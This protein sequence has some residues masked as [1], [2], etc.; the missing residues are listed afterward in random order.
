MYF[1]QMEIIIY[2]A[3]NYEHPF[4]DITDEIIDSH[5]IIN[6]LKLKQIM[7]RNIDKCYI[8]LSC[9]N[10]SNIEIRRIDKKN[11]NMD[12]FIRRSTIPTNILFDK[13]KTDEFLQNER[14]QNNI[15][16]CKESCEDVYYKPQNFK[17]LAKHIYSQVY[18]VLNEKY[19]IDI[20]DIIKY[21]PLKTDFY[22]IMFD[23][24]FSGNINFE[25]LT[26][27]EVTYYNGNQRIVCFSS[28][29]FYFCSNV[30]Y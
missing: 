21:K 18:C 16:L 15:K 3:S 5:N 6:Y 22:K 13:E 27:F 17:E 12:T 29:D 26:D 20:D 9:Y 11:M 8:Y 24:I 19:I 28:N 25:Q 4:F 7:I 30:I 23:K 14:T 1:T 2:K 10:N